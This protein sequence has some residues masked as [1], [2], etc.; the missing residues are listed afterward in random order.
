MSF[1]KSN[2]GRF[3]EGLPCDLD[4]YVPE[5]ED[6]PT[7]FSWDHS[8]FEEDYDEYGNG[9]EGYAHER[10]SE[11]VTEAIDLTRRAEEALDEWRSS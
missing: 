1:H 4:G 5:A 6:D 10:W 8:E 2:L 3:G 7:T 9:Y 11:F